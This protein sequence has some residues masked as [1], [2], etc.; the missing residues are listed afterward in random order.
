MKKI[1]LQNIKQA[2]KTEPDIIAAYLFGSSKNGQVREGSDVDLAV[3]FNRKVD[4]LR[5][6]D[7]YS[8]ICDCLSDVTEDLDLISLN[9]ADPILAFQAISGSCI[10]N[11]NPASTAKFFSLVCREYE[12]TIINIEKQYQLS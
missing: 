2:L 8:K 12:D 3:L 10:Y 6:F 7:L 11:N 5:L 1:K 9:N 4:S